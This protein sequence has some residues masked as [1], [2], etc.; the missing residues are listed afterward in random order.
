MFDAV[1]CPRGTEAW[2]IAVCALAY[3][4]LAY[5]A[6]AHS[7][8]ARALVMRPRMR[9]KIP[10]GPTRPLAIRDWRLMRCAA[11]L[12]GCCVD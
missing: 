11:R 10:L 9:S 1:L 8:R 3:S 12:M 4:A 6:T 5:S 2:L 7:P